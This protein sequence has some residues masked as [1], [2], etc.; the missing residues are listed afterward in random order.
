MAT[1]LEILFLITDSNKHRGIFHLYKVIYASFLLNITLNSHFSAI[2]FGECLL[3]SY[4]CRII[5]R[6]AKERI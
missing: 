2:I 3:I 5:D 4:L 1:D 6:Y